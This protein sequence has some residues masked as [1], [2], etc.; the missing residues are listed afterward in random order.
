[1]TQRAPNPPEVA[2]PR[3]SRSKARSSAARGY[4]FGCVC[5]HMAGHEDAGVSDQPYRNKHTQICTPSL[6]TTALWTYSN[7]AVQIRVGLELAD[8]TITDPDF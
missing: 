7:K 8:I 2:Q 4:K 5:S 6:G 3:S 1:M